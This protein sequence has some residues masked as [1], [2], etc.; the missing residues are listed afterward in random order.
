MKSG[1][2][3][4]CLLVAFGCAFAARALVN[5]ADNPY[6]AI[7]ARNVFG[8]HDPPPP[9]SPT[10]DLPPSVKVT[11]TGISTFLGRENAFLEWPDAPVSGQPAGKKTYAMLVEGQKQDMVEVV[12]IDVKAG[13]V[14]IKNNNI[15][16]T[17]DF[18]LAKLPPAS[19]P[20]PTALGGGIPP[21]PTGINPSLGGSTTTAIGNNG[22][23]TLPSR[24]LRLPNTAQS[25]AVGT[26]TAQTAAQPTKSLEQQILELEIE[27]ELNKNNP[28]YPPVPPTPANPTRNKSESP[29]PAP[30]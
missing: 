14:K 25:A 18:K 24:Q 21:V 4:L 16:E 17:L 28:K 2:K 1:G 13:T 11:L 22:G 5:D 26:T 19:F 29:P 3:V 15:P 23:K 7:V 30:P 20:P 8:L 12:K 6:H 9:P 27:A 10:N